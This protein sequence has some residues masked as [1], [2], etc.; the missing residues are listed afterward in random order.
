MK[1]LFIGILL[2][3][4][5][6]ISLVNAQTI[7]KKT[8]SLEAAKKISAA[9]EAEAIK[10]K[11]NMAI[12]IVDDGGNLVYFARIDYTQIGSIDVAIEKAKTAISFRRSTK[13][14]QERVQGGANFILSVPGII[15]VE[16]GLPIILDGQFIGAIGVSGGT[17]EQD[18]IVAKA[19][20]D[21]FLEK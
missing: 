1:N 11:W 7:T 14:Y 16:G 4:I 6:F 12:A 13:Q 18:G 17:P 10:N 8:L 15:P 9:A 2:I 3:S 20:L 21:A 19:G 5:S